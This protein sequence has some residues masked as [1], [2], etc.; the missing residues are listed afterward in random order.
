MSND[1]SVET[2]RS[3]II[4]LII[5]TL[6]D[7]DS[8]LTQTLNAKINDITK[9]AID[10]DNENDI[11]WDETG[12]LFGDYTSNNSNT[13]EQTSSTSQMPTTM[14]PLKINASTGNSFEPGNVILTIEGKGG[15]VPDKIDVK[16]LP[17]NGSLTFDAPE[18]II[19]SQNYTWS[20]KYNNN[21]TETFAPGINCIIESWKSYNATITVYNEVNPETTSIVQGTTP[22][23]TIGPTSPSTLQST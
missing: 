4:N 17:Y 18:I 16:H 12:E 10:A 8:E 13:I 5:R 9:K 22:E 6:S 11:N 1:L 23:T 20:I 7:K 15:T 19:S 21:S 2:L 14:P 3:K